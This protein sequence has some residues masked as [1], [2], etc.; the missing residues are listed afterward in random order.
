MP[1]AVPLE[2]LMI[3][4]L[5]RNLR[6]RVFAG[7]AAN[8]LG[9]ESSNLTLLYNRNVRVS[10]R[11]SRGEKPE[12]PEQGS[13]SQGSRADDLEPRRENMEPTMFITQS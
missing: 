7:S 5:I 13:Q 11:G 2:V 10:A 8:S 4:R 9:A 1:M 3:S 12:E 6:G